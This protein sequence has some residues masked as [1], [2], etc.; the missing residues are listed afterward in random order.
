MKM[1]FTV[2]VIF[3]LIQFYTSSFSENTSKTES[4]FSMM[5][6]MKS[7]TK[8]LLKNLFTTANKV[9]EIDEGINSDEE[10]DSTEDFYTFLQS[11]S[12]RRASTENTLSY[13]S[14]HISKISI[15]ILN[16]YKKNREKYIQYKYLDYN[17]IIEE[18]NLLKNKY[19]GYLELKTAQELYNLPN[20]GGYCNKAHEVKKYD[21]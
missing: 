12:K 21:I 4:H 3:C 19:P 11:E 15:N 14:K 10:K 6:K 18:L 20:P 13:L 7:K 1:K 5:M 2:Y 8:V 9:E 17:E 16:N